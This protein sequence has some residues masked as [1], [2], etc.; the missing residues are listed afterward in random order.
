MRGSAECFPTH[1]EICRRV[2]TL[3]LIFVDDIK[4]LNEAIA[5]S[6]IQADKSNVLVILPDL[7]E[8]DEDISQNTYK[9]DLIYIDK[10]EEASVNK[11][12]NRILRNE[13]RLSVIYKNYVLYKYYVCTGIG[14]EKH[15]R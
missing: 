1:M 4:V 5:S 2:S 13:Y 10:S 7:D 12:R 8:H 6:N 11:L 15:L 3:M 14:R 9:F